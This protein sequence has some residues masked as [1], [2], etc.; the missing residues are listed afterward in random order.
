[1]GGWGGEGRRT[2]GGEAEGE[3]RKKYCR[4]ADYFLSEWVKKGHE[5]TMSLQGVCV[6]VYRCVCV[7]V[8][9]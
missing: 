9:Q 3:G 1:M 7:C 4:E 8:F 2:R 5:E 6:C